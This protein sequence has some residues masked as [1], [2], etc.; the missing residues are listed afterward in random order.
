MN[1]KTSIFSYELSKI[2]DKNIKKFTIEVINNLPEYFFI[3]GASSTGKYHPKFTNGEGG[4]IRHTKAVV[5]IALELFGCSTIQNFTDKEKDLIISALIL[6]DGLKLG[7]NCEKYTVST[8]PIEIVN[9]IVKKEIHKNLPVEDF[10]IISN[11]IRT[12][13][14]EW[15]KDY[16]TKKVVLPLPKDNLQIFA[17]MCDYLASRKILEK[18]FINE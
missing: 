2:K 16:K 8:H 18:F 4:L 11:I 17:H 15:N 9:F 6:H 1:N 10:N 3:T 14:G 5:G 13:M 7:E 12:H